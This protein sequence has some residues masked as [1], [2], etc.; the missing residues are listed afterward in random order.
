MLLKLLL[1]EGNESLRV[2]VLALDTGERETLVLSPCPP[3]MLTAVGPPGM[4]ARTAGDCF[5]ST[6]GPYCCP[7]RAPSKQGSLLFHVYRADRDLD[8]QSLVD[9]LDT[10]DWLDPRFTT[11]V[12]LHDDLLLFQ[13][14]IPEKLKQ[15]LPQN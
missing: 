15:R 4:V 6:R 10:L 1:I 7:D 14:L 8:L 11:L 13:H 2:S 3:D 9:L 5:A 12:S